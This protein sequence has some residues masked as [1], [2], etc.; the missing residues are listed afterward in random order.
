MH[1]HPYCL[2]FSILEQEIRKI[3]YF[4]VK[5]IEQPIGKNLSLDTIATWFSVHQEIFN[6]PFKES[7]VSIYSPEYT[8]L[9]EKTDNA[10]QIFNTL[11]FSDSTEI[12][13]LKNKLNEHFWVYFSL[14]DKTISFIENHLPNVT[15]YCSDY[16]LLQ[17]YNSKL[18]FKNYL[19]ANLYGEEL[20]ICY[21]KDSENFYY[22]KF[23][24]KSKED[25]LYYLR[26][27][28]EHL[29]L[30]INEFPTYLYGFIEEKSPMYSTTYGFIRNFEIDRT[31]KNTLPFL[32]TIEDIPL[33]YYINLLGLGLEN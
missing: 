29:S 10:R 1:L 26:L 7:K 5:V 33:H 24:V 25:L 23:L 14:P 17:F 31:L 6:L 3:V 13:Y 18:S 19:S 20:T 21:K 27:S 22:N 32:Y 30:D 9:P 11:G 15:F 8:V 2:S 12:T 4:D 28:Y 16:G